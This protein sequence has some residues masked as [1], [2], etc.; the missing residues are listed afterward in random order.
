M[1][2]FDTD[3]IAGVLG[4]P[5]HRH[6]EKRHCYGSMSQIL[7][8]RMINCIHRSTPKNTERGTEFPLS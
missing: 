3:G 5:E 8:H 4:L 7:Q 1:K 2:G 6:Q